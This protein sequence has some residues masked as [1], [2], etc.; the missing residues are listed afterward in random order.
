MAADLTAT[1]AA[2][3]S[4]GVASVT[5]ALLG[6]E[7]Q[8]LFYAFCGSGIGLSWAASAGRF[9]ALAVFI[10]TTVGAAM[11]GTWASAELWAGAAVAR[12]AMSFLLGVVA[13]PLIGAVITQ[14]EPVAR[15]LADKLGA[16]R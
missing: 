12:N 3:A 13:H 15:G 7:P 16:K 8:A 4:A 14:L 2:A 5:V 11:F 1:T 10:F 6:V 9:R